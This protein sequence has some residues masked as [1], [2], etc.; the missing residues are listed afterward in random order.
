MAYEP[1]QLGGRK[2]VFVDW[3]LIEPGYGVVWGGKRDGGWEMPYGMRIVPHR[4]R[5]DPEPLIAPEHPWEARL[6][7]GN[8]IF[9]DEGRL[10]LYYRASH[11][12]F[13]PEDPKDPRQDMLAYAESED[14]TSWTK[15]KIGAVEFE[16]SKDNN[17]VFADWGTVFKDESA[18]SDERYKL[19]YQDKEGGGARVLG[20]VS[21]DGLGWSRLKNPLIADYVSDTQIVARFD[22]DKGRYVGYFR[23]WDRHEH[24]RVHGRRNIAYAETDAFESWPKPEPIVLADVQD[25][26]DAD[27][28]TNAY[29]PW[30]DG[31]DAHLMFPVFYQRRLDTTELHMMSSRDGV[32]WQRHSREPVIPAGEPG[33][34][35]KP[36]MD[37]HAGVYAG[38]GL[39]AMQPDE[40][41]LLISPSDTS[42]NNLLNMRESLLQDVYK[43]LGYICRATWR[44]DG[45]T[46]LEAETV[47]ACTTYPLVFSGSRL[48]LN[49][50][51]RFRGEIRIE[52]ADASVETRPRRAEPIPGRTFE[53]CDPISGDGLNGTVTWRGESDLSAWSGKPVRLRLQMSRARLYSLQFV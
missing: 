5:L 36:G 27:I 35:G 40:Y 52:V 45:F 34:S 18:P 28:Y 10:R 3:D 49:A 51:T 44:K 4:P 50:W 17:I 19:I 33:T 2:H 14:G 9:E 43:D 8:T 22:A 32:H 53:E 21:P 29:A 41:S 6:S 47:G 7:G 15:P 38:C 13:N 16:G 20:A 48:Q 24:G 30:P 37:W 23:G 25:G 26:P 31:G 42:H 11:G 12:G 39:V 46:S 1:Y